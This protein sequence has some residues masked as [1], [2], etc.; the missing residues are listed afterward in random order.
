VEKEE[1]LLA[2]YYPKSRAASQIWDKM[3]NLL[4]KN[5]FNT[6]SMD[7]TELA[8]LIEMAIKEIETVSKDIE[9]TSK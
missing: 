6:A 8:K 4:S 1:I 5:L 7:L 2:R 9:V 3:D